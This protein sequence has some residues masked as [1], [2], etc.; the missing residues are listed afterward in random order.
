[1]SQE[2]RHRRLYAFHNSK[3]LNALELI[4]GVC[5]LLTNYTRLAVL[6]I[7]CAI[8][9]LLL[10]IGY[11]LWLWIKKPASIIINRKLSDIAGIYVLYYIIICAFQAT[12]EFWY[13][14]P[15]AIAVILVFYLLLRPS[16]QYF[17]ITP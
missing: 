1:M 12:N 14:I 3:V 16:D 11:S 10:F 4:I 7:I 9:A 2:I 15:L 5:L 13:I 17:T 8:V 6:P